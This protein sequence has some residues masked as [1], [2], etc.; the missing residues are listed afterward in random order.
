MT[1]DE[2]RSKACLVVVGAF[3]LMPALVVWNAWLFTILYRWH[4]VPTFH[5][6]PLGIPEA[7][8]ISCAISIIRHKPQNYAIKKEYR[9]K[10]EITSILGEVFGFEL[11]VFLIGWIALQCR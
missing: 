2:E 1:N 4:V 11:I 9:E 10:R 3:A 5:V 8:G 7:I 6:A